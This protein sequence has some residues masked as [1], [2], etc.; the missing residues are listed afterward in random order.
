MNSQNSNIF[1]LRFFTHTILSLR[2]FNVGGKCHIAMFSE[3][4]TVLLPA[5]KSMFELKNNHV[6]KVVRSIHLV[7]NV[8]VRND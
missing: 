7:F 4:G 5:V 6:G 2:Q 1:F 3:G 8:V